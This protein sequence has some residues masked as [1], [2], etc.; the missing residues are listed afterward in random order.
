ML[1]PTTQPCTT[2]L[3][4]PR[5]KGIVRVHFTLSSPTLPFSFYSA[6]SS[7]LFFLHCFIPWTRQLNGIIQTHA[8]V[9]KHS[10]FF[11]RFC[12]LPALAVSPNPSYLMFVI[13]TPE[14]LWTW[15]SPDR[16][17][18]IFH[19]LWW[20]W[21]VSRLPWCDS[22]SQGADR[23]L[24]IFQIAGPETQLISFFIDV[25]WNDAHNI[26][27]KNYASNGLFRSLVRTYKG[28]RFIEAL[29]NFT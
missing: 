14:S 23:Q 19:Q 10:T 7:G 1:R 22:K 26:S 13:Q 24:W 3:G 6:E 12:L 8:L 5:F 27:E 20:K 9:S 15:L 2:N 28:K 4:S 17:T 21:C 29:A 18:C 16:R 11:P 25:I